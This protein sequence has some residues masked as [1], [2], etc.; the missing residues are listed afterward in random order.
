MPGYDLLKAMCRPVLVD[1]FMQAGRHGQ[2]HEFRR[3]ER[4]YVAEMRDFRNLYCRRFLPLLACAALLIGCEDDEKQKAIE[5]AE[6]SRMSSVGAEGKLARAQ[7]EIADL[8]ELL[9]AVMVKRDVLEAQ[10]KELLEDQGKAVATAEEAQEGIRNLTA[11][12]TTQTENVA[13]LQGQIDE[14][15]SIMQSQEETISVQDATIEELLKTVEAQQQSIEEQS[16][17]QERYEDINDSH[18]Y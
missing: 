1:R 9:D 5:D 10:V 13:V 4:R 15:T 11:R 7:R 8:Q 2:L 17:G 6:R 3:Q 14:L 12:S 16:G 18:L